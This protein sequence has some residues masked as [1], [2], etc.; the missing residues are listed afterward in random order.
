MKKLILVRISYICF[1]NDSD[2]FGFQG[3]A[4]QLNPSRL[5]NSSFHQAHFI[6]KLSNLQPPFLMI[7]LSVGN[8]MGKDS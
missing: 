7:I 5:S 2:T 8:W 6:V 3:I 1:E 4:F